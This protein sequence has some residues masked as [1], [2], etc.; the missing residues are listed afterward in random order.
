MNPHNISVDEMLKNV[1]RF[2]NLHGSKEAFIDSRS[3]GSERTK[4]NIIGNGVVEK[5]GD[6]SLFPNI[7]LPAFGFNL[8]MIKAM[9]GNGAALHAHTTEEAFMA[10]VGNWA[11]I[12]RTEEGDKEIILEPFDTIH[13]PVGTYR[14]FRYV[15]EGEGVLLTLIGGPDPGKVTWAPEVLAAAAATGLARDTTGALVETAS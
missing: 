8:G 3:A 2:K 15:G 14:A 10:L 7:P 1:A 13:V 11:V 5:T 9:S 4:I 12:W 6:P